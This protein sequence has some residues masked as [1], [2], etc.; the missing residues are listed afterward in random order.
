MDNTP[1]AQIAEHMRAR[2]SQ[3]YH[4]MGYH[5]RTLGWGSEAQQ[6]LRFAQ[7]LRHQLDLSQ[8]QILDIG[9]GFGDYFDF[10]QQCQQT[11]THY[12]GWDINPDL[13]G[14]AQRRHPATANTLF[15][16][17]DLAQMQP[18]EQ[19]IADVGVMLG[20]LNLNLQGTMDNL[21]YTRLML[22]KAWSCVREVLIVDFIST[23]RIPSYPYED[24]IFYHS[25]QEM[26]AMALELSS[27][28]VLL[29]DYPPI[30]QR[31]GMIMVFADDVV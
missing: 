16:V 24:F 13:I 7:T 25:P 27:K 6:A 3:R 12:R 26:L 31:E 30:P 29:Q 21:S 9:C 11:P 23:Q 17:V 20:L 22:K 15:E 4:E 18:L 28:V 19:P 10:L 14:E 5:I 1:L 2:Y 8:K